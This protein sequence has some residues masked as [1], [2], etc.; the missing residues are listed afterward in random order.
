MF[1]WFRERR[2]RRWRDEP[3][4]SWWIATL[5]RNLAHYDRLSDTERRLVHDTT[6]ILYHEKYWEGCGGLAITDEIKLTIAAQAAL[7]ELGRPPAYFPRVPTII[8]YPTAFHHPVEEDDWEDDGLSDSAYSGQAVDRGPVILA[9]DDVRHEARNPHEGA[10]VVIHE[11][12]HQLDF[13]DGSH[14]GI[15]PGLSPAEEAF[16]QETM[17][18][19]LFDH[20]LAIEQGQETFFN[21]DATASDVEFFADAIEAFY[22]LPG[23]FRELHPR[24]YQ[25]LADYFRIDPLRWFPAID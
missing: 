12:A 20:R 13:E 23:D 22:C 2:R 10:N 1:G 11:F 4:P 5:K 9:W 19:A 14:D 15:P 8:V 16:W 25:L 24:V 18:A 17:Q 21:P 6:R 7:L 3:F